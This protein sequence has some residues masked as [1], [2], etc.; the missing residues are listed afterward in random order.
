[1]KTEI[2]SVHWTEKYPVEVLPKEIQY[3]FERLLKI[4]AVSDESFRTLEGDQLIDPLFPDSDPPIKQ[5]RHIA[6]HTF[7]IVETIKRSAADKPGVLRSYNYEIDFPE[8]A[9]IAI[10]NREELLNLLGKSIEQ[11]YTTL[12]EPK[13]LIMRIQKPYQSSTITVFDAIADLSEHFYLHAQNMIDYY[14]KYTI[15]RSDS[16]KK[17]LG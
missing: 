16:M 2:S 10:N 6:T 15:P 14:E 1:M 7:A 9:D 13:K 3:R 17:A 8:L 11:L 5:L 12:Q 4:A